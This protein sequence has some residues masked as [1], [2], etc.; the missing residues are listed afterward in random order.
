[1]LVTDGNYTSG[2]GHW[3]IHKIVKSVY[4]LPETNIT[5]YINYTSV[6][7]FFK[8]AYVFLFHPGVLHAYEKSIVFLNFFIPVVFVIEIIQI[9]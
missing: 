1:M 3:V 7:Q 2:G 8:K 6:I 5:L 9:K 4:C